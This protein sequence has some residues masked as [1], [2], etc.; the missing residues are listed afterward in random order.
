MQYIVGPMLS[1]VF[2]NANIH[3]SET[4]YFNIFESQTYSKYYHCQTNN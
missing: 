4:F 1:S 3:L 2:W